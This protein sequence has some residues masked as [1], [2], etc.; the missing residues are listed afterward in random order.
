M[1][2]NNLSAKAE[3]AETFDADMDIMLQTGLDDDMRLALNELIGQRV[4]GVETWGGAPEGWEGGE[5]ATLEESTLLDCDL[6]MEEGVVLELYTI[7][8][9]PD[10]ESDPIE[11]VDETLDA[12]DLL[13]DDSLE[14]VDY[15]QV[16]EEGGLALAFGKSDQVQIVFTAGA[17]AISEWEA[18]S[19]EE[20]EA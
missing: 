13:V 2:D 18:A 7:L 4:V 14:L 9:Y 17:W 6:L 3:K 19:F 1:P 15:D 12:I 5:S 16:D 10:P 11:D 20:E 8:A